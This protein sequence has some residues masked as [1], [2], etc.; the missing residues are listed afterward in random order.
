M[1]RGE[2]VR[3]HSSLLEA[4]TGVAAQRGDHPA[5]VWHEPQDVHRL[6]N[7]PGFCVM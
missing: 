1:I 4:S 5:D 7:F 2:R 6:L 3:L